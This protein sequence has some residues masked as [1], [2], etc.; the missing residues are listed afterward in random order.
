MFLLA[1][2]LVTVPSAESISAGTQ[3]HYRGR[4]VA[5]KGDAATSEKQ[6]ELTFVIAKH[7]E[8]ATSA[9]WTSDERGRGG[10]S[11]PD[12]FGKWELNDTLRPAGGMGPSL[13]YERADGVSVVPLQPPFLTYTEPFTV[14]VTWFEGSLEFQVVAEE[15]MNGT[16]TWRVEVKSPIGRRRMLWVD[17]AS[18]VIVA[19]S[20]TVFVG[21]GEQ[22][23][24]R[25]ELTSRS[26]AD[27]QQITGIVAAFEEFL[28]LRTRLEIEPRT[29]ELRWTA[30]R[31]ALLKADLPTV[32][33]KAKGTPLEKLAQVIGQDAKNQKDRANALGALHGK[34]VGRAAPQPV[35]ETLQSEKFAWPDIKGK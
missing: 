17:K 18:P 6:F 31:L 16:E 9:Y 8:G 23:D 26:T 2:L 29:R 11:W 34:L 30:D 10:W 33:E 5:E 22:H 21:Q 3:L 27:A 14:G 25:W 7:E 4:F 13:S 20:E 35:L 12:R 1:I 24:L 19:A 32:A 15:K 28:R